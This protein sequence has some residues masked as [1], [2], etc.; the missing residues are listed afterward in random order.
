MARD[1]VLAPGLWMPGAA[2][3]LLAARLARA[4]YATHVF[5]YRGRSLLEGNVARL[6]R[7]AR[8]AVQGR[9]AHFVG[10]SLGG[11]LALEMLNAHPEQP[12]ASL[13]LLG[14]PVRGCL[15]GRRLGSARVGRWMMGG[16]GELWHEREAVW[17]R[18][19][20]LG[21]VAGTVPLG[22]GRAF[23][24][25]PGPNDG[26]VRV[27]ETVVDGMAARVLVPLGHSLLIVSGSVGRQV[28]RFMQEGRFE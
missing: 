8:Q 27:D 4:G 7:F 1:V 18:D 19:A 6:A 13:I 11:V 17:K 10:H 26:V 12:V 28:E 24:R 23:G 9:A 21:V 16:C 25:L 5:T 22:L 2:M 15:A 20:P 14:A 3:A